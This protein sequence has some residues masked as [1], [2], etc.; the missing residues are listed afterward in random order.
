[1]G[2][3]TWSYFTVRRG[4]M[5]T[6]HHH[7][8]QRQHPGTVKQICITEA[9]TLTGTYW[10]VGWGQT[11]FLIYKEQFCEADPSQNET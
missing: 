8:P 1:M 11:E 4:L 6:D 10:G 3:P 5:R 7:P 2:F 9:A